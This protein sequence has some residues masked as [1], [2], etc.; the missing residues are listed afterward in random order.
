MIVGCV[1][2][3]HDKLRINV[4]IDRYDFIITYFL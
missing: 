3:G 4:E 2:F 1:F